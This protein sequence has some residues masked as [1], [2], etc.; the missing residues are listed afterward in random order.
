MQRH[1]GYILAFA[2]RLQNIYIYLPQFYLDRQVQFCRTAGVLCIAA[3]KTDAKRISLFPAVLKPYPQKKKTRICFVC[4]VLYF[5]YFC[6]NKACNVCCDILMKC[7]T[8]EN[9]KSYFIIRQHTE[10]SKNHSVTSFIESVKGINTFNVF[11]P[12]LQ[13]VLSKHK[14]L[15]VLQDF[16]SGSWHHKAI[17]P[18]MR[19]DRG[20]PL[21]K[22][23]SLKRPLLI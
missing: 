12:K 16:S 7:S 13:L 17:L 3:K 6:L 5:Y 22:T 19:A 10:Y 4:S 9:C 20:K 23:T 18:G 8:A 14:F 2:L 21:P 1:Y 11:R 15:D